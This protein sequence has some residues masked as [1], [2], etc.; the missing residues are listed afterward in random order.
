[1]SEQYLEFLCAAIKGVK[2]IMSIKS[3]LFS[4]Y[5]NMLIN[6]LAQGVRIEGVETLL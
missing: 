1:M 5:Y 3:Y 6:M 4:N 2:S